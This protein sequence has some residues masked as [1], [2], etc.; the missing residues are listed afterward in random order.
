M[1]CLSQRHCYAVMAS[2]CARL[3]WVSLNHGRF[4]AGYV[5]ICRVN[6]HTNAAGAVVVGA[7]FYGDTPLD[8]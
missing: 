3:R 6:G 5:S 1:S 8:L 4:S 2:D 7:A